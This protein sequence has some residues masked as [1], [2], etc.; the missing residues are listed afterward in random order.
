MISQNE[1]L[2]E[3][4][5]YRNSQNSFEEISEKRTSTLGYILLILMVIF[6][7][8]VGETIFSDL[9]KIPEKPISPSSC[10]PTSI[11]NLKNLTYLNCSNNF[12]K[13]DKKF[14]L[15]TEYKNIEPQLQKIV[16]LNVGIASNKNKVST[17]KYDTRSLNED[18]NLSLQEKIARENAI[19]NKDN[20]KERIVTSQSQI[21]DAQ[22]QIVLLEEQRD[23]I[24]F[25]ITSS[26]SSLGRGYEEAK[27]YYQ[28]E[29]AWY[30]FKVFLL[31]FAFVLPLFALSVYLYLRLKRKNSPY[32]IILTATTTAFSILFLQVVGVF[33]YDIL[34]KEWFVYIFKFLFDV[35]FL[36]YIVYYGFVILVIGLFG[37][38]VYYIQKKVFDP[39]KIAVRRLKDKKC[40][41]CS[42]CLDPH[43]KFCPNCGLQLK[44]ECK[45]CGNLKIRYLAYCP[46]CGKE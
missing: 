32:T 11:G 10:I 28:N 22:S 25:Q 18:Y 1:Q 26:A 30:Q 8:V 12:N 14:K 42:F 35:P 4:K 39:I 44:E 40:P 29:R 13:I 5:V 24:I 15:D 2:P 36:R 34:P 6:V 41:K 9:K 31:S 21:S 45:Y 37:G 27:E 19:L 38:I 43:H 7:I 17:L 3:E 33:L 16:A 20:I 46:D 23:S